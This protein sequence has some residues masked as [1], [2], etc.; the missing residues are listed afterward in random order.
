M[1]RTAKIETS[2]FL[3][4]GPKH[5]KHV[6][7]L[8]HGAGAPMT[9]P[10]LE[11]LA[12][13]LA[14]QGN[15]VARF[16]FDYMASRRRTGIR[17]PPPKAELLLNEYTQAITGIS[18]TLGADQHLIIGGKSLGGRVASMI[19]AK[20]FEDGRVS[21]LIC[22]GYPFHPSKRPLALRTAHLQSL[23]CPA[24]FVQGE[25]DPFGTR[26]EVE[27]YR[28]SKSIRL[29]WIE[30]ADH[31]LKCRGGRSTPAGHGIARAAEAASHFISQLP[32]K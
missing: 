8:A 16:E 12:S 22:F 24:L 29:N 11:S 20:E 25:N 7:L 6:I 19:A 13:A 18:R 4:C 14:E 31:D 23:R 5:A 9:S 10:F 3:L 17:R 15:R 28:L 2:R 27:T 26:A 32:L 30:S 1:R 21:A